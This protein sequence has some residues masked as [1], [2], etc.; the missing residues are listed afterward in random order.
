MT[1]QDRV[2]IH[3]VCVIRIAGD[4][5]RGHKYLIK[6]LQN[7]WESYHACGTNMDFALLV[8]DLRTTQ[9]AFEHRLKRFK[10]MFLAA[11]TYEFV[12]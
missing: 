9:E 3:I 1:S 6:V 4:M 12:H 10:S 5:V 7:T 11:L 8:H 2:V